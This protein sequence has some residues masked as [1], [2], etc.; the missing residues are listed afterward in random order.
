MVC[1]YQYLHMQ[2]YLYLWEN[3]HLPIFVYLYG[4]TTINILMGKPKITHLLENNNL[5]IYGKIIYIY[6]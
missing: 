4:K 2:T 3:D 6:V 5:H 1:D